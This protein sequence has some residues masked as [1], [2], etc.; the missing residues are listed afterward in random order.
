MLQLKQMVASMTVQQRQRKPGWLAH[1]DDDD[2]ICKVSI[3]RIIN[4]VTSINLLCLL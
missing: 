4:L 3:H 2:N 1:Y